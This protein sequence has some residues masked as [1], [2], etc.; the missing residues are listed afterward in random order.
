[1]LLEPG[2]PLSEGWGVGTGCVSAIR[3][4]LPTIHRARAML[5]VTP[6]GP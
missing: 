5:S 3:Y 2:N 1:M 4:T 6:R